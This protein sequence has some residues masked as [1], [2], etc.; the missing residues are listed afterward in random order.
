MASGGSPFIGERSNEFA[1]QMR[2]KTGEYPPIPEDHYTDELNFLVNACLRLSMGER[3]T[4]DQ[5]NAYGV[6]M[7]SFFRQHA[8]ANK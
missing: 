8:I 4:A 5:V 6:K 1:L 7:D 2:V 3:P